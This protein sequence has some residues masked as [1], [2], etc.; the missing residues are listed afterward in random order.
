LLEIAKHSCNEF[1]YQPNIPF[2][3]SFSQKQII[4]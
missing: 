1:Y 3:L 2:S 4:K